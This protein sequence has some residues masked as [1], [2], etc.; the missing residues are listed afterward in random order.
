MNTKRLA[1][2]GLTVLALLTPSAAHAA[3]DEVRVFT[4]GYL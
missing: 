1:L 2:T 4:K 3:I